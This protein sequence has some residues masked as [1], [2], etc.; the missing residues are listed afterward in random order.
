MCRYRTLTRFLSN[1]VEPL[2]RKAR[3]DKYFLVD[4]IHTCAL[5]T[6]TATDRFAMM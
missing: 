4:R 3:L 6:S 5:Q 2:P 1:C